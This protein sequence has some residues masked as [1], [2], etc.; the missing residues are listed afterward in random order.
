MKD[1]VI[2]KEVELGSINLDTGTIHVSNRK[3]AQEVINK[4]NQI[5]CRSF[6]AVPTEVSEL[7]SPEACILY[8]HFLGYDGYY[9]SNTTLSKKLNCS[10]RT[11]TRLLNELIEAK[12]IKVVYVSKSIRFVYPVYAIPYVLNVASSMTTSKRISKAN[13]LDST[14]DRFENESEEEYR[15]RIENGGFRDLKKL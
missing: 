12:C 9:G 13:D 11:I 15:A 6:I 5:P 2:T 14:V 10:T 4:I 1:N 8:G 3:E 7:V